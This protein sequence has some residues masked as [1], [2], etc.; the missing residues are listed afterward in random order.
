MFS[1]KR[2]WKK[3]QASIEFLVIFGFVFLMMIPLIAIFFDQTNVVQDTIAENQL[4]NLAIKI[5]DKAETIYYTGGSSKT[6][7]KAFLPDGITS[8][9]ISSRTI[10]IQYTT[11][12][13]LPHNIVVSTLVNIT[14]NVSVN[15]GIH[16]IEI[17]SSGGLVLI[18]D[19]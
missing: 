8:F 14:G 4:R 10:N 7:V 12:E 13:G 1:M 11:K 19:S 18:R 2:G 3:S 15:S 5:A 9:N 17:V 6:T 16:N